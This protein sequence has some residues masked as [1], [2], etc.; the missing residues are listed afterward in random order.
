[1]QETAGGMKQA[2]RRGILLPCVEPL[3][4]ATCLRE[5]LRRRQGT[6]MADCYSFL[7][8]L[9]TFFMRMLVCAVHTIIHQESIIPI[10][11]IT[12][13]GRNF[14]QTCP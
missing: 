10:H 8:I 4:A 3:P 1:M 2:E 14:G 11:D 7:L 13:K 12:Y 5:A 9:R 6:P